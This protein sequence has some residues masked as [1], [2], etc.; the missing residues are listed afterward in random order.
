MNSTPLLLSQMRRA[1]VSVLVI[2]HWED[3]VLPGG[4][5]NVAELV[6]ADDGSPLVEFAKD[7]DAAIA[8]V[9]GRS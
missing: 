3:A 9:F 5:E 6:G 1:R 7:V 2:G 8:S 4:L